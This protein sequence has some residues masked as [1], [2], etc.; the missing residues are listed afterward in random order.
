MDNSRALARIDSIEF[1]RRLA[2]RSWVRAQTASGSDAG[3]G[4]LRAK[5]SG[6]CRNA[7]LDSHGQSA[8][9]LG[10]SP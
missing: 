8:I 10:T 2:G 3:R 4:G 6:S 5:R 1:S 7:E 9:I